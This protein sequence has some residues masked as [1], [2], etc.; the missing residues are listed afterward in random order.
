MMR[1]FF[2]KRTR[3]TALALCLIL[4]VGCGQMTDK[5]RIRV[6]KVGE[7]YITRGDLFKII[8]EM[9]DNV[10]PMI[11]NRSDLVRILNQHI[12][13]SI[14]RKL[15]IQ[16]A[17]EGRVAVDRELARE[18]FFRDSGDEEESL[19]NMWSMEVPPPGVITPL[20]SVYEL[21]PELL[22]FN[23][24]QVE[25]GTDRMIIKLQG[26]QAV[27]V[28]A[29]EAFK[30]GRITLDEGEVEREYGFMKEQFIVPEYLEFKGIRFVDAP[31]AA[32]RASALRERL[33]AGE[34]FDSLLEEYMEKEKEDNTDYVIT[35]GIIN[36]PQKVHLRAF[37]E[38]ASGAQ[39]GDI[40]GPVFLRASQQRTEDSSGK[41]VIT[42]QPP[43]YL[44]CKVIA[45]RPQS[46]L[47]YEQARPQV[48][49]PLIK[50]K[51]MH[52]LREDNKVEIYEDKLPDPSHM[53]GPA[54]V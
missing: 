36:D 50:A 35:A 40:V 23:K 10:R 41:T 25:E 13:N 52:L 1:C 21:T 9:P 5:D 27:E 53:Q 32:A 30:D 54:A 42:E 20:M 45:S 28:L 47:P 15:G 7:R 29:A 3:L 43:Y 18:M 49:V 46:L 16:F 11:R 8:R 39:P 48:I 14:K 34:S 31:D 2:Q 51:M 26:E 19:R 44:I 37:W 38:A 17:K 24:D 33:Q 4:S 12:D 6:A 22:Q